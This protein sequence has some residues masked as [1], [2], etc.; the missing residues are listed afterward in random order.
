MK[1]SQLSDLYNPNKITGLYTLK[2]KSNHYKAE[3]GSAFQEYPRM[4]ELWVETKYGT[5]ILAKR[6]RKS[7]IAFV[8]YDNSNSYESPLRDYIEPKP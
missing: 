4:I 3:E 1:D 6:W 5:I 8:E 2:G 7:S